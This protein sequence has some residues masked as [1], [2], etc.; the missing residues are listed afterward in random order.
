MKSPNAD[1]I[2]CKYE[3]TADGSKEPTGE[4][5]ESDNNMFDKSTKFIT[6]NSGQFQIWADPG[7]IK[8]VKVRFRGKNSTGYGPTSQVY[9][10][11]IDNR[12]KPKIVLPGAV[13][14]KPESGS[15]ETSPNEVDVSSSNAEKIYCAF[16]FDENGEPPDPKVEHHPFNEKLDK[17]ITELPANS[18]FGQMRTDTRSSKSSS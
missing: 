9:T 16:T 5:T 14:V 18:G 4:P 11:I 10:Y 8:Y 3:I 6:G 7:K 2:Y 13:S 12:E 17:E 1:F 15:W